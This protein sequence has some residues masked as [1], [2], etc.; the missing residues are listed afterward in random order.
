MLFRSEEASV[1]DE[2]VKAS[3]QSL[4]LS[5]NQ[6]RAGIINF[7][8][9]VVAQNNALNNLRTAF[10]LLGQRMTASVQLVSALG[11]G[12]QGGVKRP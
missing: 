7:L 2:A 4:E 5:L 12:W 9:V 1:Q 6:Y 10:T 11:G 8:P 3:N